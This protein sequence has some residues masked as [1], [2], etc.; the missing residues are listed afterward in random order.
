MTN[1]NNQ[2]D[3]KLIATASKSDSNFLTLSELA[4]KTDSKELTI[5]RRMK[6][7]IKTGELK[8]DIDYIKENDRGDN[9]HFIYKINPLSFQR[10]F[11]IPLSASKVDSKTDSNLIAKPESAS[12]VDSNKDEVIAGLK[13]DKEYLQNQIIQMNKLKNQEQQLELAKI[14]ERKI[15]SP[16]R[17]AIGADSP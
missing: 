9:L 14:E 12:K 3:N 7:F 8:Q 6:K 10:I 15:L 4:S 5:R 16:P 1:E 17:E 2:V 13:E 11:K